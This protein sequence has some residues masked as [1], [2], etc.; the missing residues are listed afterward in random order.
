MLHRWR[1]RTFAYDADRDEKDRPE[2]ARGRVAMRKRHLQI[3]LAMQ[4]IGAAG[5]AELQEK[6]KQKLP[7]NLTAEESQR[8]LHAGAKLERETLGEGK[9][10][11]YTRINVI[12]GDYEEEEGNVDEEKFEAALI[13][14][15]D[16]E[17]LLR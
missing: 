6:L 17:G 7:L 14:G 2:L 13:E 16:K 11:K 5:L 8:L 10:A 3:A 1:D 4:T 12:L 9:E 15:G